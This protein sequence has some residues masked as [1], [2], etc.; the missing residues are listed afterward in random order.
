[1]P[2]REASLENLEKAMLNWRRPR[3]WRSKDEAQMIRRLVF[4]W[5]TSRGSK[6]SGR[7]WA[8]ALGISHTWLQKLARKFRA[9]PTEMWQMQG[10]RGDPAFAQLS[11]A[12][13]CTQEM[14]GRGELRSK[15]RGKPGK[16][17]ESYRT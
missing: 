16:T 4:S 15:R 3:P 9:D 6:P 17:Q 1:M 2:S 10:A 13:E 7:A 12:K 5:L 8:R 14:R 11:R